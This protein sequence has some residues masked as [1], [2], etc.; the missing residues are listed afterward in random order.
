[1]VKQWEILESKNRFYCDGRCLTGRDIGVFIFALIL[2]TI[3]SGLFFGFDCPY[4]TYRL[5]P[6]VPVFA[7]I[8]FLSVICFIFRTACS[9][10]GILPRATPDEVLYLERSNITSSPQSVALPGRTIEVQMHTGHVIQ[11]K[12]CS[13]CK[14]FRPPRVSHCSLCDACIANFDHHCPWV[15]NCVG[16]RNYRYF[17]SFLMS[18]SFLC[19]Y[20]LAFNI[21]NIVLR[22]QDKPSFADAIRDTPATIVEALICFFSIWSV[23]GLWGYHTYLIC[24]SVTTNEDIK[25]T[26]NS[27]RRGVHMKNP[28]SR[29]NPCLNCFAALCGPLPP[30]FLNLRAI[31]TPDNN[32]INMSPTRMMNTIN[33][34]ETRQYQRDDNNYQRHSSPVPP[35][36]DRQQ[37]RYPSYDYV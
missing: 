13:T 14:I 1:M 21:I 2:I 28:F 30:S 5:S 26:W 20:I 6:A 19:I 18:L 7:A 4:L 11:L 24:R 36:S 25:D 17:Y 10:P 29:G 15:G 35:H 23:L 16:L 34:D 12:F 9:D 22:A 32:N 33:I 37:N 8:L 31:V 27:S 3:T